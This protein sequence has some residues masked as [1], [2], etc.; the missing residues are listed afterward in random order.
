MAKRIPVSLTRHASVKNGLHRYPV[1]GTKEF[2]PIYD[3][4]DSW[5]RETTTRKLPSKQEAE[6]LLRSHGVAHRAETVIWREEV[7]GTDYECREEHL[8]FV[9]N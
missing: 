9:I 3:I 6:Q 8:V 5:V 2:R 4:N 7:G 1:P